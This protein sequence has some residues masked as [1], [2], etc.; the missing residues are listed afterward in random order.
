MNNAAPHYIGDH[1]SDM[2]GIKGGWYAMEKNG[3]LVSGP[4]S[5]RDDCLKLFSPISGAAPNAHASFRT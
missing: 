3:N 1:Q 2:R 4:F 5:H